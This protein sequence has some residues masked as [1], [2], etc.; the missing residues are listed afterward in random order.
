MQVTLEP[1][2][3]HLTKT[4]TCANTEPK[5]RRHLP[6]SGKHLKSPRLPL[7]T[8]LPA[9][10][11]HAPDTSMAPLPARP[12]MEII[13]VG[14]SDESALPPITDPCVAFLARQVSARSGTDRA[15][16]SA[17]LSWVFAA[18]AAESSLGGVPQDRRG[19]KAG[20]GPQRRL[21]PCRLFRG[22]QIP[23]RQR[24]H[25]EPDGVERR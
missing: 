16:Q 14:C 2:A 10:S 20:I 22:I 23:C 25:A 13:C 1:A 15:M 18:I 3:R 8:T 4:R 11:G 17:P 9:S 19:C 24:P 6:E 5:R 7:S 21:I 12:D